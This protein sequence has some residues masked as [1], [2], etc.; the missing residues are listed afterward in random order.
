MLDENIYIKVKGSYEGIPE[1][2]LIFKESS[3]T[4]LHNNW[5]FFSR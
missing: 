1:T 2:I 5:S 4:L 3:L